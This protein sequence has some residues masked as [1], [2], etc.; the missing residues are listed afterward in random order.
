MSKSVRINKNLYVNRSI[1][2]FLNNTSNIICGILL[3]LDSLDEISYLA[4]TDKEDMISYLPISKL[5]LDY[6]F[7]PFTCPGRVTIKVG[8]IINK[9]IH[10]E[11][12]KIHKVNDVQI[13]KFVNDY[14]SW[15]DCSNSEIKVIEGEEIRKWYLDRNYHAPSGC[16]MGTLWNS[17]M[18][19]SDRQK[20]L[21]LYCKNPNIKM[22]I[23]TQKING[24]EK[25]R[26]RALL[27]DNVEVINHI[28]SGVPEN[29]KFM[30]RIYSVFD[31]DV[32]KFKRW[33]QENNYITKWEQNSKSHLYFNIGNSP[34]KLKCK[35]KLIDRLFRYY[36]YLDTF[37]F[38]DLNN[39]ILYNDEYNQN[40]E[41]KLVQ[42]NGSLTPPEPESVNEDDEEL[43]LDED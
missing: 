7:D 15:F 36:P 3:N 20:Y 40:W 16:A 41:Y 12:L 1:Y 5:K 24:V 9:L 30:D 19:Y 27:W 42:A 33:A 28:D 29:I 31:S 43:I 37:P 13:E 32:S 38:F 39:G 14:K 35:V 21:D 26:S 22:L 10:E 18:R 8:R 6:G 34:I 23:M 2:D 11:H 17:C 25:I 4:P